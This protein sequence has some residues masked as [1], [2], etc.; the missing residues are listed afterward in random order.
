MRRVFY[1]NLF[2]KNSTDKSICTSG[3]LR[4]LSALFLCGVLLFSQSLTASAAPSEIELRL[5]QQR[6]MP[7][8]SN[9][10][11]NWP[12]GPVVN[13]ESAILMELE[14]GTI[15]YAKNIHQKQYPASTTKILTTLI[16]SE[17]CSMDEIVE[18]SQ[19]AVSDTPR[20]SNH[21]ALDAGEALTV[22]QCL[23]AILIRSA[24][25]AAFALAEH[26]AGDSWH[27]FP[28]IMNQRAKELGCLNSNFVNPNGLPDENHYTTAYDLAMIGR[29]FFAN[30]MLCK[31][32][33]KRRLEIPASD[34]QPDDILE[35]NAMQIIPGGQY[36]YD[37]LV[38]CKTGYTDT[39]RSCL[40]SCA[41][42]AGMKLICVVLHDESPQQYEDTISLFEYG[43]SNF[44]KVN[45]SQT[46]TKY[47]IDNIGLFYG[48]ND[49]FGNS[50][51]ILSLNRDDYIILPRT[52]AFEDAESSISYDTANETQAAVITYSYH[53]V[54]IGS[55]RV[56]FSA[57]SNGGA[58]M[59]DS[60]SDESSVSD[61]DEKNAPVIYVNVIRVLLGMAAAGVVVFLIALIRVLLK[62]YEFSHRNSRRT[63]RKERRRR[64][65]KSKRAN[66]FRDFDL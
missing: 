44:E 37:Y 66:R 42:R 61:S 48:D 2:H 11:A 18:I 51:P 8:Q 64:A 47:D 6:A 21:I 33:L 15:L 25:E 22:E 54:D 31:I 26:I 65:K 55:V 7:I 12:A 20:N 1:K 52:I 9:Q 30:D 5:E 53:G 10:I 13:A 36:A 39:A 27:N 19:E 60:P 41:E 49:I 50:A 34:L 43:F 28:E 57:G 59:F 62:N 38:G 56:N 24:N 32:T 35:N 16:A 14:T 58:Y 46:E 29:A 17:R 40:V 3:T 63:W 45:V 23:N 4:R